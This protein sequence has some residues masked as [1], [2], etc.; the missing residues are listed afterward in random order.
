MVMCK[1]MYYS[2]PRN[3]LWTGNAQR[4]HT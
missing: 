4:Q 2:S 1:M 3:I